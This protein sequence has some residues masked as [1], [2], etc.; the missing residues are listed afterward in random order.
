MGKHQKNKQSKQQY[1]GTVDMTRSGSAYI[2][3]DD[4][5]HDVYV[6]AKR[7]G[8]A[9]DGDRV[10][11]QI[12]S[13]R[14]PNTPEGK[15]VGIEKRKRDRYIGTVHQFGRRTVVIPT[16]NRINMDILIPDGTPDQSKDGNKV[17]VKIVKWPRKR[18]KNAL[19]EITTVL[20][21]AGTSDI[22]MKAILINQGFN[23]EF[24]DEVKREAEQLED[25]TKKEAEGGHRRDFREVTTFTIDPET[26]KDFDDALSYQRL[27]NGD[28]EVGIHIADVTHYVEE[29]SA[30]DEEAY[31]RATSVYL[32]DR[33]LPMLPERLSNELC[34][35]RPGEDS[36]TFSAVFTFDPESHKVKERWFG[37]T[38]IHST[39]RFTYDE[40]QEIMDS[41]SGSFASEL[42]MLNRIAKSLRKRKFEDG[43]IAFETDEIQFELNED[44]VPMDIFLKERRDAHLLVEDF[45]LLANREVARYIAQHHDKQSI[46]FV[47]RVH[48]LPDI[49][50]L[51]DFALFAR[52]LGVEFDLSTPRKIAE[53][54]NE[55]TE[56]S[57]QKDKLK[58]LQPMAIRT[59]A[60]AEY[61]IENI[62]HYGLGFDYYTHFTSP[63]RRYADVLV[64]RILQKNLHGYSRENPSKLAAK[65]RH[66]SEMER[67]A[68]GA[69][70][71]SVKYKQIEY[72]ESK[73]G[74][75][76]TGI[77]SG[78]IDRGLFVELKDTWCE[79]MVEFSSLSDHY[80][81]NESR[82]KAIGRHRGGKLRMGDEIRVKVVDTDIDKRQMTLKMIDE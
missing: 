64:H 67:Q 16:D 31:E 28:I 23:L 55:L 81:I 80:D 61:S 33:T 5:E 82:F 6:P 24:P 63:I 43:A 38:L 34:S 62:G 65:C 21:Q 14:R 60:K 49:E 44:G 75:E 72:M 70:R 22:E 11:I 69:E 18:G 45:M 51:A 54:F 76:F 25:E 77:I 42:D 12:T 26:A 66:I 20:G 8:T 9:M 37:K 52:E 78:M 19:G 57:M 74:E 68:M 46:P 50:R 79:G 40:A 13:R 41:G 48:D 35:L 4:L 2:V 30:L 10:R 15:V 59:M 17:V 29:G 73:V 71:E 58:I 1:V 7:L 53:S 27:E 39:R 3:A 47:Y 32:V 56:Q 36:C